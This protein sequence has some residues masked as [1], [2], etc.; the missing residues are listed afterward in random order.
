MQYSK[1]NQA[2]EVMQKVCNTDQD[3]VWLCFG[4][5][6]RDHGR[7]RCLNFLISVINRVNGLDYLYWPEFNCLDRTTSLGCDFQ[8]SLI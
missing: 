1:N 6:L 4:Q 5:I 3:Q 2:N 8:L 7:E